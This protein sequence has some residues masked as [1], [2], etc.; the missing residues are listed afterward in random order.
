[1][2]AFKALIKVAEDKNCSVDY[3]A[4][5]ILFIARHALEFGL[6]ANIR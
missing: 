6:K 5:S 4:F 2:H 3:I 1:M